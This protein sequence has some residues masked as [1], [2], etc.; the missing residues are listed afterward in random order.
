MNAGIDAGDPTL[1]LPCAHGGATLQGQLRSQPE[2]FI[3][4]EVLG[5]EPSGAGEHAILTVRKRSLNT[6]DV[7]SRLARLAGVP[8]LSVGYAGLKD[9]HALTT[10]AFSVQLSGVATPDWSALEREGIEVLA[11][12][13]HARKIRRGALAGNRFRLCV[14]TVAGDREAAG[15]RLAAIAA[16]GVPNAFGPQRF[17]RAG[18]NLAC[19]DALLAGR[20]RRPRREQQGLWLSAARSYR[21]NRV[22]AERVRRGAWAQAVEGDVLM[23]D[24][25]HSQFRFDRADAALPARI[26]AQ[27]VHPSGPL[28]GKG[29]RALVPEGAAL[30]IEGEALAGWSHWV[31]GLARLGVDADRR[32]LRLRVQ[33]L[34]WTWYPDRLEVS[35]ALTAGAYA[36]A[37]LRE[38]VHTVDV[39]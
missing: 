22:L 13:R 9:R 37:V 7:A 19:A 34:D 35:F 31:E 12:Q 4:E 32:A 11:V 15:A 38:V 2:D 30:D 39:D 14:R 33:D 5:W 20:M 17:G 26:T 6:A 23:L 8:A 18:S 25:T 1:S 16:A 29:S 10:Q 21:F 3:V 28:P 36:T 27:D 24:G